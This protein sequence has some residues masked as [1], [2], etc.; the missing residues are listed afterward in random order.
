[1]VGHAALVVGGWYGAGMLLRRGYLGALLYASAA[2][3]LVLLV[4]VVAGIPRLSTATD[5]LGWKARQ[6]TSLFAVQ[7]GWAFMV[8]LLALFGSAI[9]VAIELGR[10]DRRVTLAMT[11]AVIGSA[12][13]VRLRAVIAT[14]TISL[15]A[16]GPVTY[17]AEVRRASDAVDQA[18]AA[19]AETFAPY[20]WTR[21][22]EYLHKAR[23]VAAHADFQAANR[24]G[25]A[26]TEAARRAADEARVAEKD[27]QQRPLDM[28]NGVSPAK[29]REAPGAPAAP[30]KA[31]PIAPAKD[32]P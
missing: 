26:A 18:K 25:R 16:C 29:D 23:E 1:M 14:I 3:A 20:W 8:A 28:P 9:Y 7:L 6:G 5:Y 2:I 10:D 17:I 11:R 27:P 22:T 19:R 32:A 30:V 4:L 21:A 24:F 15:A 31:A 13:M 12:A